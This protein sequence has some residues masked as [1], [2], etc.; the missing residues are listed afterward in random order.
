[1]FTAYVCSVGGQ[2]LTKVPAN[3]SGYRLGHA[4][5]IFMRWAFMTLGSSLLAVVVVTRLALAAAHQLARCG[6]SSTQARCMWR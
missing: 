3:P 2:S 6:C 1:M 5:S 4:R